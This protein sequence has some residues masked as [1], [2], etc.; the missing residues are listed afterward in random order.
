[1]SKRLVLISWLILGCISL[2]GLAGD[3]INAP[4][5][6]PD[7]IRIGVQAAGTLAWEL[8]VLAAD[9]QAEF[10]LEQRSLANAEAGKIAL[11]SGA[12]DMIVGDWIWAAK[13]RSEGSDLSFYPYS[14]T[15]GSLLTPDNSA[16]RTINDLKGQRLGIAGGELDK[17]WLLLQALAQ[18]EK[19]DLSKVETVFG[20]PPLIN[21][22]L[23]QNRIDAALNYWHFG[24]KLESQGYR[25]IIN[26][27]QIM[28]Q[29]GISQTL[30]ALG[31][32]FR[33]GWAQQHKAA[34]NAFFSAAKNARQAL[35]TDNQEW[36]KIIS[37]LQSD[38]AIIQNT[39]RQHYCEGAIKQWG[40]A[41]YQAADRVYMLLK[42][43][44]QNKITGKFEHLPDDLFWP[45]D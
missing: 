29:L 34:L 42:T 3:V 2:P 1:M 30:P 14:S 8:A 16:I 12:V 25:Q 38:N 33:K 44:S 45:A 21:E 27:R 36:R 13:M 18:Q 26:G 35:C 11:Q 43:L 6:T 41:E 22:Q 32:L 24:A 17:N 4:K 28:Q 37:L 7:I 15:S 23:K 9:K 10:Q 20:A 5:T 40:D 19:I 39:L 31:Y